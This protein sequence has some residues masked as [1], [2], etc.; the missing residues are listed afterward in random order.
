MTVVSS[1]KIVYFIAY[2]FI[3]KKILIK[4]YTKIRN[5]SENILNN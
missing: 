3:K 1:D 4:H 5:Y 2:D